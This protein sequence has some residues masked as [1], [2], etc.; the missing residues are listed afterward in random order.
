[1]Q[2]ALVMFLSS[3]R[4]LH[5]PCACKYLSGPKNADLMET[6]LTSVLLEKFRHRELA[7]EEQGTRSRA[8]T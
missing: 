3:F 6:R 5:A 7:F 4:G 2:L 8:V 1:M